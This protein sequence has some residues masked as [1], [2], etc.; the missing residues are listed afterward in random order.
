MDQRKKLEGAV[1]SLQGRIQ[2]CNQRL[3]EDE[4]RLEQSLEMDNAHALALDDLATRLDRDEQVVE[5]WTKDKQRQ[6]ETFAPKAVN[7][8][9]S[10][11]AS[12]HH[13]GS[14][15]DDIDQKIG[16]IQNRLDDM[17]QLTTFDGEYFRDM[18]TAELDRCVSRA[19]AKDVLDATELYSL[20][21]LE[22]E[23]KGLVEKLDEAERKIQGLEARGEARAK[24]L[25]KWMEDDARV[26]VSFSPLF[27]FV[28]YSAPPLG[29][30]ADYQGQVGNRCAQRAN[31]GD[32]RRFASG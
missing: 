17:H 3:I 4:L 24:E 11:P 1:L 18:V 10:V 31:G 25:R 6:D 30:G 20:E 9:A 12:S 21:Q 15:R 13:S 26:N 23:F 19:K 32:R 27:S 29:R 5:Q 22:E 14:R 8:D 28:S 2:E 16:A 7:T